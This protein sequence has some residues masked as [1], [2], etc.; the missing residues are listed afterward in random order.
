MQYVKHKDAI[1]IFRFLGTSPDSSNIFRLLYSLC[2]QIIVVTTGIYPSLPQDIDDLIRLFHKLIREYKSNTPLVILLDSLDQLSREHAAHK[3]H[4]LPKKLPENVKIVTSTYIE[5]TDIIILL[6]SLFPTDNFILVPKLGEELSCKILKSWLD[7][8]NR[9]L[10]ADQFNVIENAFVQCSLPIYVKLVFESILQWKSYTQVDYTSLAFTVKQSIMQLFEHLEH[11]HSKMFV[12]RAFAYIT[13][14]SS[15]LSETELEDILSTDDTLLN[16]VFHFHIPPIIRIPPLLFV[17]LRH[18]IA[19]YLVDREV[20]DITVF[21]WYHRQ[22]LE[23]AH[24]RYLSDD[25]FEEQIHS[26]LAEYFIGTWHNKTK[27]YTYSASQVKK[28]KLPS[29]VVETDRKIAPQPLTFKYKVGDKEMVRFNKRKLNRLPYH[30]TMAGRVEETRQMCLFSFDFLSAKIKATSVQQ[31][32]E[33]FVLSKNNNNTLFKVLKHVQTSLTTFPK[34]LAMEI[35]G[36]LTPFLAEK[37]NSLEK[38]L[39]ERCFNA[40]STEEMPVP[41]QTS[42]A[43]PHYALMYKFEHEAIPF[44]SKLVMISKDS[45]H[46]LAITADNDLISWDLKTGELEKEIRL[47]DPAQC[48][49]NIVTIDNEKD[50][51][52]I[53][54]S[55]QKTVNILLVI[56]MTACELI[57]LISLSKTYPG[58]GFADSLKFTVTSDKVFCLYIGH[59]IDVF[60]K[61]TGKHLCALDPVPDNFLMLPDEKKAVIHVKNSTQF[62]IYNVISNKMEKEFHIKENPKDVILAPVGKDIVVSYVNSSSVSVVNIDPSEGNVGEVVCNINTTSNE[63]ILFMAFSVN[64]TFLVLKYNSGFYLWNYKLHKMQYHY[65]IPDE[66]KPTFRVTE[67]CGHVTTGSDLFVV[68]YEGYLV[69]YDMK[70]QKV[71]NKIQINRS[72]S[73]LFLM[74]SNGEFFANTSSRGN[75][76]STWNTTAMRKSDE[77][78]QPITMKTAPRYMAISQTGKIGVVRGNLGSELA[79]LDLIEGCIKFYIQ[80]EID[81]MKPTISSDGTYTVVREYHSDQAVSIFNTSNGALITSLPLTS[82]Q[83]KGIVTGKTKLAV[84]VQGDDD[85]IAYVNLYSIPGG[86]FLYKFHEGRPSLHDMTLDFDGKETFLLISKPLPE[87][88]PTIVDLIA[89]DVNT[90]KEYYTLEKCRVR[91]TIMLKNESSVFITQQLRGS[92]DFTMV[93]DLQRKKV[94]REGILGKGK[95]DIQKDWS[96]SPDG[97]YCIDRER[98]LYDIVNFKYKWQY[99]EDEEYRKSSTQQTYPRFL[100]DNHTLVFPNITAGLLKLSTVDSPEIK[101]VC[102]LHGIPVCLEVTPLGMILVGCDDGRVI[103]LHKSDKNDIITK[104]GLDGIVKRETIRSKRQPQQTSG[105]SSVCVIV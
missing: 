43:V 84:Y 23:A 83:V 64:E 103:M 73:E 59:N 4:W 1:T 86:E 101:F 3:L 6:K 24:T 92:T 60:D 53:C 8:K 90:G 74:S 30:L 26:A 70:T 91:F 11:K 51:C 10:T 9:T 50:I 71:I 21:F 88:D 41:Y 79:V 29:N 65:R 78:A 38:L 80:Q 25:K 56:N 7:G 16:D 55:Y 44:G 97:H 98:H 34:T 95:L 35:S 27:P 63:N 33:D 5:S 58:V 87:G 61:A 28:L 17:R 13:A 69:V 19:S 46:L 47:Y 89:Y 82:L 57:S 104:A 62:F 14:S 94:I 96:S 2:E 77:Q 49:L 68:A 18:D 67:F 100:Y 105:K 72:K 52:Y 37:K 48:K 22:F 99:D 76:I 54:S 93:V 81:V 40:I 39:V 36:H 15:G 102:P 45:K 32:L 42:F 66:V 20:D 75:A 12:S 31:V 85:K